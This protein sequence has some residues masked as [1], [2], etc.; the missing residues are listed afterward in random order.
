MVLIVLTVF[1]IGLIVGALAMVPRWWR[2]RKIARLPSNERTE[3]GDKKNQK[4]QIE[5]L[6]PTNFTAI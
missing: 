4:D 2:A 1:T 6:Q 3:L 5:Q